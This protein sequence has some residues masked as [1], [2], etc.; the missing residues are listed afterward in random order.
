MQSIARDVYIEDK[1]PGVTVGVI[2]LPRGLVQ[3]DSPPLPEDGHS[4]RATLLNL[5]G[6]NERILV[7]LDA[8][9]DRTVG[10]R[11]MDCTVIAQEKAVQVIRSRPTTFK[12]QVEETGAEW[13]TIS[14]LGNIRWLIPEISFS[15]RLAIHWGDTPVELEYHP[16]PGPGATWL[17]LQEA[18]IVFVGDTVVCNQPPF[19]ADAEIP[20]WIEALKLLLS[21][22]YRGFL[23]I[24]GRGGLAT[25]G[26]IRS[27]IEFLGQVL[28]KLEKLSAKRASPEGLENLVVSMAAGFKAHTGLQQRYTQ[29]LRYGLVQYY[30]RRYYS[31]NMSAKE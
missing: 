21:P 30:L 16:G 2:S 29:R 13:E 5:G 24:A 31:T 10:T 14:G 1:Y 17:I 9:P 28:I 4:W 12:G 11:L 26:A 7:N 22:A 3:V 18:R 15:Q 8:H 25:A 23:V 20:A 19:L 6:G 27:Q